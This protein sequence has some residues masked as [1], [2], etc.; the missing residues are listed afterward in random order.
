MRTTG[1]ITVGHASG[2]PATPV[3]GRSV[4]Y[5]LAD[6]KVYLVNPAGTTFDLTNGAVTSVAGRTG[7]VTLAAA[8]VSGV[9]Y[10]SNANL[11]GTVAASTSFAQ[12]AAVGVA[13]NYA[14]G[15][16]VHG[17]PAAPVTSAVAGTA[18]SVS[19]A[20]G[21]VTI[22]N[23]GATSVA[24]R[25]GAVTLTAADVAAGTF[26]GANSFAGLQTLSAGASLVRGQ[27]FNMDGVTA[28]T[29]HMTEATAGTAFTGSAIAD[30]ILK[31][32]NAQRILIGTHGAAGIQTATL[33]VAAAG[34][35]VTGTANTTGNLSENGNRVYSAGN[36]PPYP[37]TTVAGRTGAVTLA[38]ADVS[39]VYYASNANLAATVASET[40]FAIAAAVGT[41]TTYA[42]ADHT[43]GTPATPVTSAVAGTAIS[44]SGATGAVTINNT[45]VTSIVAGTGISIS[46]ATGA[47][48]ITNS[49]AASAVT[50]VAGRT[51]AVTLTAADIAAGTFPGTYVFSASDVTIGTGTTRLR[52][53]ND[54][55]YGYLQSDKPLVT[56]AINSGTPRHTFG[57]DGS[58]IA[59]STIDSASG[60]ST[61]RLS[62]VA[63]GAYVQLSGMTE[64]FAT[65][66]NLGGAAGAKTMRAGTRAGSYYIELLN[67]ALTAITSSPFS[68]V[69][70][71]PT[72]AFSIA[73]TGVV[74][75]TQGLSSWNNG[76]YTNNTGAGSVFITRIAQVSLT[77]QY[78]GSSAEILMIQEGDGA[79]TASWA[80]LQ[81][82]VK[83]QNA[84]G[85]APYV[86]LV[87][88]DGRNTSIANFNAV[89][90]TNTAGSTVVALYMTIPAAYQSWNIFPKAAQS[91]TLMQFFTQDGLVAALPAGTQYPAVWSDS[92]FKSMLVGGSTFSTNTSTY[93]PTAVAGNKNGY[94][95]F[96]FTDYD[97]AHMISAGSTGYYRETAGYWAVQWD[98]STNPATLIAGQVPWA[99][100]TG[101]PT[102]TNT[103][104]GRSGTVT[105]TAADI[106][107][108]TFPGAMSFA[109]TVN[110]VGGLVVNNAA[111]GYLDTTDWPNLPNMTQDVNDFNVLMNRKSGFYQ[112][113]TPLNSPDGATASANWWNVIQVRHTNTVNNYGFQIAARMTGANN[114]IWWRNFQGG[115]GTDATVPGGT[116]FQIYHTG[117]T[118]PYPV[119]SVAGKTGAVSLVATDIGSGVFTGTQFVGQRHAIPF[120]VG[121]TFT[122][123]LKIPKWIAPC[124]M[125][126]RYARA[127]LDSGSGA[128]FQVYVNGAAA[129]GMTTSAATSTTVLL[130][131]FTD[132]NINAGDRVQVYIVAAGGVDLSVT[133]EGIER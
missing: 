113:S 32:P 114:N 99:R 76:F 31:V 132:V 95:G 50:S 73:S 57:T 84:M 63:S 85:S 65:T 45:G 70:T 16:H 77:G 98:V 36:T 35:T 12:A 129:T 67:D 62:G 6:G 91:G 92:T 29:L 64:A 17:T 111:A 90:T 10:A 21:A 126:L 122:T 118:P 96:R 103:V 82:R 83:Q 133:V 40:T 75:M 43:H 78:Q 108:G 127:I 131:D 19:G 104:A 112:N 100:L 86:D 88:I 101:V 7:A 109:S 125:T 72:G 110:A 97:V 102:L 79:T 9:Y 120:H 123:G 117:N 11:S 1:P 26:P 51:G 5:T 130:H 18:I 14:R 25:T 119:T 116:W 106:A 8:D 69:N 94:S 42:R 66:I 38:A 107:S 74:S 41:G 115:S 53:T 52:L 24:G 121:G 48:T 93:S 68:I 124:N 87:M 13:T 33:L 128:T 49:A 60:G 46:G 39:G 81:F 105:L 3:A 61:A 58:I 4:I 89:L 15:D 28:N 22:T 30:L 44:V 23:T 55:T 37:V 34:I 2:T 27:N 80:R 59:T 54:T 56:A 47:V 20:T 71:A